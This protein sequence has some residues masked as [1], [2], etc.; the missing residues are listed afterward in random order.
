MSEPMSTD[1]QAIL[2]LTSPLLM[3]RAVSIERPLGARE[4]ALFAQALHNHGHQ[5][6]DLLGSAREA[7]LRDCQ[8]GLDDERV[9]RLLARGRLLGQAV[10]R[11]HS[12]GIWVVSR[13]DASYPRRLE[14]RLSSAAPAA[15]YGA[16]AKRLLE[17]G[18]LAVLGARRVEPALG[19]YSEAIGGLLAQASE[20]TL[21][22]G[23]RGIDQRASSA[24]LSLHGSATTVLSDNLERVA[25][26]RASRDLM[27]SERLLLVSPFDPGASY[28][29][30][31]AGPQN[32]LLYALADALLV[33]QADPHD[34][35]SWPALLELLG[36]VGGPR[37]YVDARAD[38]DP[39]LAALV[40]RGALPWP[41]PV[42]AAGLR[43]ALRAVPAVV[44]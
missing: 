14:A 43:A 39:A 4:Y 21:A 44:G 2:L 25:L 32:R 20:H 23:G 41:S 34:D 27:A 15:L 13:A 7:V 35:A 12:R 40:E 17:R 22:A 31:S 26:E 11:W 33:L 37:V 18:G 16:G 1:T 3:G 38:A 36:A 8:T 6:A 9:R 29:T 19:A 24:A 10:E 42:D 30:A 5:P 28:D